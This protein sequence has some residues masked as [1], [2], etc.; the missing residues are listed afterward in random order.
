MADD[1]EIIHELSDLIDGG[2]VM[3]T[4]DTRQYL[5][6]QA[7]HRLAHLLAVMDEDGIGALGA[8][9]AVTSHGVTPPDEADAIT[10]VDQADRALDSFAE[11]MRQVVE[12]RD[13]L[14]L[15]DG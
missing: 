7:L 13:E 2:K 6:G 4:S 14:G 1:S 15:H 12:A 10:T 8:R 11:R 3:F 5:I 9:L